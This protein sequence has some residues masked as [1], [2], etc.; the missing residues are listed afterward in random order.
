ML[1]NNQYLQQRGLISGYED[2]TLR[3]E[4]TLSRAE[5]VSMVMRMMR[6]I[7]NENL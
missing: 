3:P 2:N 1:R 4:Q 5:G 6:Y 7:G